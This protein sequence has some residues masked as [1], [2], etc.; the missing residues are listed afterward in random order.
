MISLNKR[1]FIQIT[2]LNKMKRK[3]KWTGRRKTVHRQEPGTRV[4]HLSQEGGKSYL[5]SIL[6]VFHLLY[7]V[8]ARFL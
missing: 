2:S 8:L 6:G 1:R 3:V 4:R 5:P 7:V